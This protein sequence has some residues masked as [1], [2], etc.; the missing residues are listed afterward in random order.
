MSAV[1]IDLKIRR[2]TLIA[3]CMLLLSWNGRGMAELSAEQR[4][5]VLFTAEMQPTFYGLTVTSSP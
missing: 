1:P 3:L 5:T 4:A 2:V